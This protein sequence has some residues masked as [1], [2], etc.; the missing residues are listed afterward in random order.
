MQEVS[1]MKES[2]KEAKEIKVEAKIEKAKE[3]ITK[4]SKKLGYHSSNV[5]EEQKNE[6]EKLDSVKAYDMLTKEIES[7]IRQE[8]QRQDHK[9]VS[10]H[11]SELDKIKKEWAR[12]E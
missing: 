5:I 12:I 10:C 1:A 7:Q 3:I 4:Y 6:R 2:A 8:Q 9:A 11:K